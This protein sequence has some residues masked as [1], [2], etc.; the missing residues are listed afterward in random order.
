MLVLLILIQIKNL[1][2]MDLQAELDKPFGV[3][4]IRICDN[5]RVLHKMFSIFRW[6]DIVQVGPYL[7]N[8]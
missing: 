6:F 4:N 3:H 5:S 1:D 8:S 7:D 2:R